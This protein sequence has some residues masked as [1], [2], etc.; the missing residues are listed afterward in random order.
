MFDHLLIQQPARQL[1][2]QAVNG[3]DI[4]NTVM[5]AATVADAR[6]FELLVDGARKRLHH[7]VVR[8]PATGGYNCAGHVFACRRTAVFESKGGESFETHVRLIL[9]WD[10]YRL[11]ERPLPGDVVLYWADGRRTNLLHLGAVSEVRPLQGGVGDGV[12]HV[13][14]K[15]DAG[16]GECLHHVRHV[17]AFFGEDFE[18]EYW[19]DR[20]HPTGAAP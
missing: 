1:A 14:S 4:A 20:L 6:K 11:T 7:W 8:K 9:G 10:G 2:L 13:L 5:P 15:W 12:P 3:R 19:T 16:S 17:P 18:V